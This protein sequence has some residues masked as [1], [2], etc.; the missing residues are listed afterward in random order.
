ML[1]II[2][3]IFIFGVYLIFLKNNKALKLSDTIKG[4]DIFEV[5]ESNYANI[6][7]ASSEDIDSYVGCK[8]HI[9]GYVYRLL[10]F[11]ENQ[12]VI[13]RDMAI[14]SDMQ[15][16]VVGFLCEYDNAMDFEDGTWVDIVGEIQKGN[17]N[18]DIAILNILSIEK[19]EEPENPFVS[20][21]DDTYIPT[22]NMF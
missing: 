7:K 6:L 18:G 22:A 17:F 2:I 15:S 4:D 5:T 19:C 9:V 13:A 21:P 16:L 12:F 8:V 11:E 10:D 3:G 14:S 20:M 1:V